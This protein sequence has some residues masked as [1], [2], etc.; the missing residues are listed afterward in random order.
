MTG[1][2]DKP[3]VPSAHRPARAT[4]YEVATLAGVSPATVSR[5]FN[6][7]NVSAKYANAVKKAAA[8]LGFRPNSA[9]RTLRTRTS[10]VIT[11]VIA[12]IE[13]PFFTALARGVEE[14]ARASGYSVVL[15]NSD[16][17]EEREKTYLAMAAAQHMAGVIITPATDHTDVSEWLAHGTPVVS[18]DRT[19]AYANVDAVMVDNQ[20]GARD[21]TRRLIERGFRR[22]ACVTGPS[23]TETADE[24]TSGWRDVMLDHGGVTPERYLVRALAKDSGGRE[25]ME[26]LLA[27]PEPPDAVFVGQNLMGI[28]VLEALASAG[29]S[30]EKFGV[31]I[32]G[33][34]SFAATLIPPAVDVFSLPAREMGRTAAQ[35]ILERIAGDKRPPRTVVVRRSA[36]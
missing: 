21:A 7:F 14:V 24:R 31:S 20:A 3:P 30:P 36:E 17:D 4:I 2:K 22:V 35:L 8:E 33:D 15:C 28:G 18:V 5:V 6:G 19:L 1:V 29:I 11:L 26:K 32:L 34:L 23:G 13:N 9:A 10:E 27:L 16:E 12:D 25:A